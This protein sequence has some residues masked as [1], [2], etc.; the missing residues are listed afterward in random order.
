MKPLEHCGEVSALCGTFA[1]LSSFEWLA[2]RLIAY[3]RFMGRVVAMIA[4]WIA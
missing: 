4:G 3:V 1:L 2:E